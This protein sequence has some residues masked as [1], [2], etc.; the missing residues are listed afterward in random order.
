[1]VA[2]STFF[3]LYLLFPSGSLAT[4][5]SV[6]YSCSVRVGPLFASGRSTIGCLTVFSAD[7]P[8]CLLARLHLVSHRSFNSASRIELMLPMDR[9]NIPFTLGNNQCQWNSILKMVKSLH[10]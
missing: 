6:A 7:L 5:S 9:P 2:Y 10:S 1:M 8:M 3:G 4:F